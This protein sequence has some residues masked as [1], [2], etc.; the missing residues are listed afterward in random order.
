MQ[1]H[2]ERLPLDARP[3]LALFAQVSRG[4]IQLKK[5]EEITTIGMECFG[6]GLVLTLACPRILDDVRR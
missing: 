1:K 4:A 2:F 6:H 5:A 3:L